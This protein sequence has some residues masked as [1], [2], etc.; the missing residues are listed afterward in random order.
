M[1][2]VNH[3]NKHPCTGAELI[4]T[5]GLARV[6]AKGLEECRRH[7]QMYKDWLQMYLTMAKT[8]Y[9]WFVKGDS[10]EH[11]HKHMHCFMDYS[12]LICCS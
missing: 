7:K 4:N 12:E 2:E 3:R 6:L 9:L 11:H 5:H 1:A 10:I 8:T